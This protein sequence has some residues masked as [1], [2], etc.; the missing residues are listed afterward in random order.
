ME[1]ENIHLTFASQIESSDAG[2]RLISGVVLPFNTIGNTSAGPVIFES[3]SVEIPE[4]RRIKLL[5]QHSQNDPIG[6]AQSFQVT[7]DKIYGTFKVSA[8]QKGTDYL[9]LASEDL[10]SSLSI[11]VDVVK[12][13]KNA[14]GMV[15]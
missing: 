11:G 10:V 15:S 6:R 9:T 3:G 14:K 2:R 4:A 13:K 8:S 12:A 1:I 5:A 7:Q